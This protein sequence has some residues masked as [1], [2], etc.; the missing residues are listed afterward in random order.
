[1]VEDQEVHRKRCLYYSYAKKFAK[2]RKRFRED[3]KPSGTRNKRT[4]SSILR[5]ID[6]ETDEHEMT[7]RKLQRDRALIRQYQLEKFDA[8][9]DEEGINI[10]KLGNRGF[11]N[12]VKRYRQESYEK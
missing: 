1:M 4:I 5:S 8:Q 12:L 9:W 2:L 6:E 7:M 3:I 10:S 11:E